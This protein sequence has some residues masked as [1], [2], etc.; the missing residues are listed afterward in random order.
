MATKIRAPLSSSRA[1]VRRLYTMG[2][3]TAGRILDALA[4]ARPGEFVQFH[5]DGCTPLR[6]EC[7]PL[8]LRAGIEA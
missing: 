1:A 2:N 3:V 8:Y 7:E 4:D 6:C 5:D